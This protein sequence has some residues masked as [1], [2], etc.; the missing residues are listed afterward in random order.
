VRSLAGLRP[1]RQNNANAWA[2]PTHEHCGNPAQLVILAAIATSQS[3]AAD[4]LWT[5][6][7]SL[8]RRSVTPPAL[9]DGGHISKVQE[10]T[11]AGLMPASYAMGGC[12]ELRCRRLRPLGRRESLDQTRAAARVAPLPALGDDFKALRASAKRCAAR[13]TPNASRRPACLQQPGGFGRRLFGVRAGRRGIDRLAA[14]LPSGSWQRHAL[15]T[16]LDTDKMRVVPFVR[17]AKHA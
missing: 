16:F 17:Q 10:L 2:L 5:T 9:M 1:P 3:L 8:R 14:A 12:A 15:R 6:C 4:R 7:W 13:R 11:A